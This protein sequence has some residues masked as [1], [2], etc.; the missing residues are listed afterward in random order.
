MRRAIGVVA[1]GVLLVAG[2]ALAEKD[3]VQKIAEAYLN[4]LSGKGGEGAR[5]YL[6]GGV[7]LSAELVTVP[8]WKVVKRES[9]KVE[10][11]DL[12]D[13]VKEMKVYD[14][15]GRK[16]LDEM[17]K[18][19]GDKE[20]QEITKEQAAKIM[21]PTEAQREKFMDKFPLFA[22]VARVDKDIY[23]HPK[24]PWR[25]LLD[26][27]GTKGSYRLEFHRFEIEETDHGKK[28]VWPLRVLRMTTQKFDTGYK[29]LPASEWDPEN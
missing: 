7:T 1:L 23:W 19:A 27:M 5:E 10:E 29:I 12:A 4:A 6:L 20:V 26:K 13:A 11:A 15:L 8:N 2:T 21:K 25:V 17:L 9:M 22:K 14:A 28:R 24:N 3:E 16:A 18:M